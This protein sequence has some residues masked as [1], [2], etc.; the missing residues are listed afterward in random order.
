MLTW[1][2]NIVFDDGK[3]KAESCKDA[4][5]LNKAESISKDLEEKKEI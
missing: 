2:N 1:V 3:N 4:S 5:S